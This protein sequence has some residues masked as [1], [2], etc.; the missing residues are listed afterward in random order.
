MKKLL[1]FLLTLTLAIAPACKQQ[2]RGR[3]EFIAGNVITGL[4]A[5]SIIYPCLFS[6]ALLAIIPVTLIG[7]GIPLI[8]I[9]I[10]Q[11]NHDTTIQKTLAT[12]SKQVAQTIIT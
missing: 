9:G 8:V 12:H 4:G 2:R 11:L 7:L 5:S 3:G 6:S 10:E 1:L